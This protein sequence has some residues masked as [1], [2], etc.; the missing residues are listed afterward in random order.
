MHFS[1]HPRSWWLHNMMMIYEHVLCASKCMFSRTNHTNKSSK[2]NIDEINCIGS[3]NA[4]NSYQEHWW[5]TVQTQNFSEHNWDSPQFLELVV[6]HLRNQLNWKFGSLNLWLISISN[7]RHS[8]LL[9]R[10][11]VKRV[12]TFLLKYLSFP[13]HPFSALQEVAEHDWKWKNEQK[14]TKLQLRFLKKNFIPMGL[15]C[16]DGIV[17]NDS[18]ES[19]CES[20]QSDFQFPFS[21]AIV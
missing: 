17:E 15:H 13:I 5:S 19:V 10:Q 14:R 2:T 20:H 4:W 8:R 6:K 21:L 7:F 1:I 11:P 16:D 18:D 12:K 9:F 3:N